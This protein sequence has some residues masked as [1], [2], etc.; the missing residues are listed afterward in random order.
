VRGRRGEGGAHT[1]VHTFVLHLVLLVWF[2]GW[3]RREGEEGEEEQNLT[4]QMRTNNNNKQTGSGMQ[5]EEGKEAEFG[6][7]RCTCATSRHNGS[8]R[9]RKEKKL[10]T[11]APKRGALPCVDGGGE[12]SPLRHL[13]AT[14]HWSGTRRQTSFFLAR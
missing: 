8:V 9:K 14:T 7:L 10:L 5:W 3:R 11:K 6:S 12:L 2:R 1:Y 13:A 4:T